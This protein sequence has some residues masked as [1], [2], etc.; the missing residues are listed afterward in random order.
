MWPWPSKSQTIRNGQYDGRLRASTESETASC[1]LDIAV[2]FHS[3]AKPPSMTPSTPG[4]LPGSAPSTRKVEG[5]RRWHRYLTDG[6]LPALAAVV[7]PAGR[8]RQSR[9]FLIQHCA[10]RL[11]PTPTKCPFGPSGVAAFATGP[12]GRFCRRLSLPNVSA[13]TGCSC[14]CANLLLG[15][16]GRFENCDLKPRLLTRPDISLTCNLPKGR[17]TRD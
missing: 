10:G 3:I 14:G 13:R 2:I 8:Q 11:F 1:Q 12:N 6:V 9:A 7:A 16:R 4:S 17:P 15:A 5:N